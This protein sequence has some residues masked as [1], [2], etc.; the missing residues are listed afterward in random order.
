LLT[1]PLQFSLVR[2]L[3]GYGWPDWLGAPGKRYH[4][5]R[6]RSMVPVPTESPPAAADL[7]KDFRRRRQYP[8]EDLVRPTFLGNVLAASED[9]AGLPYGFDAVIAWPR[10]Y[11]VLSNETRAVVDDR[12][13]QLDVAARMTVT[14][15]VIT[16]VSAALLASSGWWWWLTAIP[17]ALAVLAY[18]ASVQAAVALGESLHVAFDLHRFDLTDTLRMPRPTT[19]ADEK[20]TNEK[21]CRLWRGEIQ[22]IDVPYQQPS[23]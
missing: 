8:P 7:L 20:L 6:R 23:S 19:M 1:H 13:T 2:V 11:P 12:R 21:L 17:A 15:G 16:A 22:T 18:A 10:I 3:E 9:T 14:A 4:R 5:R